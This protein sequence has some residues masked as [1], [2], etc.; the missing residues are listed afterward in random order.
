MATLSIQAD[1][2]GGPLRLTQ[3]GRLALVVLALLA[4]ALVGFLRGG[5]AFGQSAPLPA[6]HVIVERGDT[7]WSIAESLTPGEDP[8]VM[9]QTLREANGLADD[10]PLIPGESLVV[11]AV[12]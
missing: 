4:F 6:S 8:R 2:F 7:L 12:S 10:S 3:R 9:V 11:P 1:Q 5:V